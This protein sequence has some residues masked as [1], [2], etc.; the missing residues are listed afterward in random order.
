MSSLKNVGFTI[1]ELLVV[2]VIIAILASISI[3]TYSGIQSRANNTIVQSDLTNMA[4]KIEIDK[5][6]RG[7]YLPGGTASSNST[8]LPGFKFPVSRDAYWVSSGVNLFYCQGKIGGN[9]TFRLVAKS[10]SG[11]VYQYD[12]IGG[13]SNRGEISIN[14]T[15]ACQ[16]FAAGYTWS[17][18]YYANPSYGW[19]SWTAN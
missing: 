5:I 13:H 10:K 9:D 7:E 12:A 14:N 4:K 18:G 8:N 11:M 3:V 16:D 6:T 2:I 19:Y 15:V 1:V 17:Y